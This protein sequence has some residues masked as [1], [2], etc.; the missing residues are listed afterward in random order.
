M[1]RNKSTDSVIS[2]TLSVLDIPNLG[3]AMA[4][5]ALYNARTGHCTNASVLSDTLPPTLIESRDENAIN[6]KFV[7]ED[8]YKEK[9]RAFGI[10]GNLK[11]NIL[12]NN[13]PLNAQF[14]YLATEKQSSKSVKVSLSYAVQTKLE[15]INIR[16]K[17]I[18]EYINLK[19]LNDTDATHVV[20]GIQ[21]G[22]NMLCSFEHSLE[23]GETEKEVAGILGAAFNTL[24]V[25]ANIN[26]DL[27][28]NSRMTTK[29]MS[30]SI[31]VLGDIVPKADSYPASVEDAVQLMR[32]VPEFVEGV[33]Q[34]KG[35]VLQYKLE[36]IEKVRA[37]FDLETKIESMINNVHLDLV[38]KVES[39]LDTIVENRIRLTEALN[40]IL[41]YSQ[42]IAETEE[43]RIKKGLKDFNRDEREFKNSLSETVRAIQA[44]ETS[45]NDLFLL[46][47]DFEVGN[48][49]SSVVD[50]VIERYQTLT[51]RISFI[52]RCEKVNIQVIS[53]VNEISSVLPTSPTDKTFVLTV[54]K[55]SDYTMI[56]QSQV[57][58]IFR[59]LREDHNDA[60][61][62]FTIYDA[63]ISSKNPRLNDLAEL[64]IVKYHGS[65]EFDQ[66][67]FRA[68]ILRPSIKLSSPESVDQAERTKLAGHALR[69]PCPSSHE[70]GCHFGATKWV[71]F[72]C[73]EVMQYEYNEFVYCHCG[74]T[75]IKDCT[76]RCDSIEH[77]YRY[78]E[79]HSQSIQSIFEKIYPG[80]D[81]IN[82]LLLGETGVGKSTFINAFA[83]YL[84][85]DSLEIAEKM[86]MTTLIQSKFEIEGTTV[87]AGSPDPD[88]N[89]K[90]KDGQSSTQCC[91]SYVFPL[92]DDIKI[93]LIDTPGI[94][95]TRGVKHDRENFEEIMNYISRF[96]KI[97]GIC[98][99]LLPDTPRLTTSFRFCIDE[100]LLHL[101]KSAADNIL[102]TFTKTRSSFYG[103]GDTMTLLRTYMK[104]LEQ[105][106]G[107]TIQLET[108]TLFYFDNEA[109]RLYAA[110]KQGLL[111]FDPK[112]RETFAAS[113]TQ[114]VV[115][116]QRLVK[117]VRDLKPHNTDETVTLDRARR[118][119]ILLAPPMT[120]INENIT[121]EVNKINNLKVEAQ[122][123][124][125]NAEELK[126][127]LMY[128]NR[129]LNPVYLKRPRM[130]CTSCST[131]DGDSV[132]YNQH[133][134]VNCRV[135]AV[136]NRVGKGIL[137]WC[138]VMKDWKTCRA[139]GCGWEEHMHL[140]IDYTEV[141]KQKIDTE[142][143][144]NKKLSRV[145]AMNL[146]I[147]E[148][149]E[150]IK[151]LES[152][153]KII[154]DSLMTFTN[155][156]LRNSILIQNS[157]IVD[158]IDMSIKNQD[159]IAQRTKDFSIVESLQTQRDEFVGQTEIIERAIKD[160]KFHVAMITELD[161][162]SA[163]DRLCR[164]KVNGEALV[165][166]MDWGQQDQIQATPKD[167]RI[168]GGYV[169]GAHHNP[170]RAFATSVV[171][172][173][174]TRDH[175][176]FLLGL[177]FGAILA[178]A[179]HILFRYFDYDQHNAGIDAENQAQY[180][181]AQDAAAHHLGHGDQ[182]TTYVNRNPNGTATTTTTTPHGRQGRERAF[183][184]VEGGSEELLSSDVILFVLFIAHT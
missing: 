39:T 177:L 14:K 122:N 12:A 88:Q 175:W 69:M 167:I 132:R 139:C 118:L 184:A 25:G 17:K 134:H 105:A 79:L 117:R 158:Y 155:F 65:V 59:L 5:G 51:S 129:D 107:V 92:N 182:Q 154:F 21:W 168:G 143:E 32:R 140:K 73:E 80:D 37:H 82:I 31:S 28:K 135:N 181:R 58:H 93:R 87:I 78:K 153:K 164:L 38:D 81:E 8:S 170:A 55:S 127:R 36:P 131:I 63:S 1:L 29:D 13:V 46:L 42:Y 100:L 23:E 115:E 89:E 41:E 165:K 103:P 106:N 40:D 71:C 159:K 30:V 114:S 57:W 47:E 75:R 94:G 137:K 173:S 180:L 123:N 70:G 113:W 99:L 52:R 96:K 68:S 150:R 11:L 48:C 10:D 176:I 34:G 22:A 83:N 15:R 26:G 86:E 45:V 53:R 97:S 61:T 149:D 133:C 50:E 146:A 169:T 98:I 49:S 101:H 108:N 112:I 54:P 111:N 76:F 162:N 84:R 136:T 44:G 20:T 77:G 67:A 72:K 121:I 7:S 43:K 6:T 110:L 124:E 130:V 148:A 91:R 9:F 24:K 66:D 179:L 178:A 128:A 145:D 19:A 120:Q 142:R 183:S 116:A 171:A 151:T 119:I 138:S 174:F 126:T 2:S 3:Q 60:Q 102:F 90:L 62:V 152:E 33:N 144:L 85:Y 147:T 16:S 160:G 35:S 156:L 157:G 95:D 4:L 104:E 56:E 161:V 163:R 125:I 18:R 74:K 166:V 27:K 64:K 141:K 172:R 109:F